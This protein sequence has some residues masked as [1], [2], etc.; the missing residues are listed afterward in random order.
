MTE[1]GIQVYVNVS[2]DFVK[3]FD[4]VSVLCSAESTTDNLPIPRGFQLFEDTTTDEH[5]CIPRHLC[6]SE[7]VQTFHREVQEGFRY[8]LAVLPVCYKWDKGR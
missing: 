2:P 7:L 8:A 5:P 6:L 4:E 3:A 1:N